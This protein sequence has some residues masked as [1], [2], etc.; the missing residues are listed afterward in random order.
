[1]VNLKDIVISEIDKE[2]HK[3]FQIPVGD[4]T[5]FKRF[6]NKYGDLIKKLAEN[7]AA[8][9]SY[10][11]DYNLLLGFEEYSR[12]RGLPLNTIA[13]EK[14][15]NLKSF[16]TF[17]C[18]FQRIYHVAD[19]TEQTK[20][21]GLLKRGL[22]ERL[23][24]LQHEI[25][26]YVHLSQHQFEIEWEDGK[27]QYDYDFSAKRNGITFAIECKTI[28]RYA[29]SPII[30]A[31]ANDFAKKIDW[32]LFETEL[33]KPS[34]IYFHFTGKLTQDQKADSYSSDSLLQDFNNKFKT[35]QK[36]IHIREIQIPAKLDRKWLAE[37]ISEI[38]GEYPLAHVLFPLSLPLQKNK[39]FCFVALIPKSSSDY[40]SAFEKQLDKALE[41]IQGDRPGVIYLYPEGLTPLLLTDVRQILSGV[42]QSKLDRRDQPLLCCI[43]T[44]FKDMLKS[45]ADLLLIY[46][47]AFQPFL[48]LFKS[49][50]NH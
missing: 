49:E 7:Q 43:R 17:A 35:R 48:P 10:I 16:I 36:D 30:E 15:E 3:F 12:R 14:R 39:F 2:L 29:G 40:L 37:E 11:E 24:P 31:A 27:T 46:N 28:Y 5:I 33:N 47:E 4:Q 22:T 9:M 26:T 20:L 13:L 1:M 18:T 25:D 6:R 41:Q 23:F 19:S 32:S 50:L 34:V 44:K 21:L 8:I 45:K 42:T 38:Y